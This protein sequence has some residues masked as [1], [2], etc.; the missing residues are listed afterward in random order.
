MAV[1]MPKGHPKAILVAWI[2]K[3]LSDPDHWPSIS[4]EV[5][6]S[7]LVLRQICV[8]IKIVGVHL[9]QPYKV[10]CGDEKPEATAKAVHELRDFPLAAV[11]KVLGFEIDARDRAPERIAK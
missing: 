11:V 5:G 3:A 4:E 1:L 9:N 7:V 8:H 10:V 2:R 6:M